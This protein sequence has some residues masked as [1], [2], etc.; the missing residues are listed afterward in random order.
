MSARKLRPELA[1]L[2]LFVAVLVL[3]VLGSVGYLVKKNAWAQDRLK[4][5]EPRYAMMA[6]LI[7]QKDQ[8]AQLQTR[9]GGNYGHFVHA[10]SVDPG[11]AGNEA[12]QRV[13]ELASRHGLQVVSSQVMP[14]RDE[15]GLQRIGLNLRIEGEYDPLTLFLG[16][17]GQQ[18]PVIYSDNIQI[19]ASSRPAQMVNR[20]QGAKPV[21][22]NAQ[23]LNANAQLSLFILRALP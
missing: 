7:A 23:V 4:D 21:A 17:L 9:L 14:P 10:A 15:A 8:L 19:T 12:L 6:G 11:Q 22:P 3:A 18:A 20:A 5:A 2:L 13:R 1:W 16:E